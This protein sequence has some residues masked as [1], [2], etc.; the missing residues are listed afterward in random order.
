[1]TLNF[2]ILRVQVLLVQVLL[3]ISTEHLSPLTL[4]SKKPSSEQIT[5]VFLDSFLMNSGLCNI[6][7]HIFV[8]THLLF[9][10]TRP[11]HYLSFNHVHNPKSILISCFQ[12]PTIERLIDVVC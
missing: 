3:L 5:L 8:F 4:T 11:L 12:Y 6:L 2:H 10:V 9:S 1:M 7:G